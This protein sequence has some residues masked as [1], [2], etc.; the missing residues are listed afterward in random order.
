MLVTGDNLYFI[1]GMIRAELPEIPDESWDRLRRMISDAAGGE[2]VYV[3]KHPKRSHLQ[4]IADAGEDATAGQLAKIL[5][6]S[7]R[8]VQRLKQLG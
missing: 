8:T 5:G 1:L 4:M 3:P 6:V 7:V 2:R